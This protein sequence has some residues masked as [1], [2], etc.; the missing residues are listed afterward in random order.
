MNKVLTIVGVALAVAGAGIAAFTGLP[1]SDILGIAVA[2]VG[3]AVS[4]T[5]VVKKSREE[6]KGKALT[7]TSVALIAIGSFL[8]GFM[9]VAESTVTQVITV[10]AGLVALVA[11]L[12]VSIKAKA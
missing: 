2:M 5:G 4:C 12:V 10:A 8:M 11:G 3:A 7:Y 9:G 6:G 1:M